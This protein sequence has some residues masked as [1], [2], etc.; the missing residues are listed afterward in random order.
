MLDR[1]AREEMKRIWS[2]EE[3]FN[4]WLELELY[5][6]EAWSR[7]G[8][9]PEEAVEKIRNNASF[10]VRRIQEIEEE[11]RHDVVAFTRCLAENLGEESRYVHYGLT[12]SDVVD[13]A[14]SAA[15]QE[16]GSLIE[17]GLE[18]LE[19]TLQRQALRYKETVMMG[20][21][22][23]VH[24]EPTSLG[25]KFALWMVEL[26]RN[27]DRFSRAREITRYGKLSG[28]VGNYANID[29]FV[30]EYVCKCMGLK[31]DPVST[32]VL[33][34]DRHAEYVFALSL[35][36]AMLEKIALEIRNL[37]RT[38]IREV[39]EPFRDNQKGSSAMPHK[40]N[41]VLCERICGLSRIVRSQV[42]VSMENIPLWHER[43]ISHS[44]AER[45]TLPETTTVVDY[46][47]HQVN[48]IISNLHVIPENM[49]N[50]IQKTN[51]LVFSQRVLLALIDKG[52]S[53]EEAYDLVQN[54]A[55]TTWEKGESFYQVLRKKEKVKEYLTEKELEECFEPGYYLQKIDHIYKRLGFE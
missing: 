1:Y 38:E 37:Q 33:Q 30:E 49:L 42:Q 43:D 27:K 44:S 55:Q 14:L 47:I 23:G 32:Q 22:H 36:A 41:P 40:R 48:Y 21:T 35:I 46:M 12:S 18:Q 5:A 10:S 28:A 2:L 54:A 11:T 52:L 34:R 50:N 6:C 20:R 15:L 51:G 26:Q 17:E 7:L 45:I 16:A 9:I 53:R 19:S 31:V 8:M 4:R 24:A 29:P 39:E 25:L 13:T 3:K